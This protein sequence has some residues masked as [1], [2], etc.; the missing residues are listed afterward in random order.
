M[1]TAKGNVS[2]ELDS[3]RIPLDD[4]AKSEAAGRLIVHSAE[5]ASGPL[6]QELSALLTQQASL[7]RV[8]DDSVVRFQLTGGRVYHEGLEIEFPELSLRTSGWVGLDQSLA[9]T[10]E[11]SV[12]SK[13]FAGTPLGDTLKKQ[14]VRIPIGGTLHRPR[15]DHRE[16]AKMS[17]QMI[18]GVPRAI[19]T[20][21]SRQLDRLFPPP[22]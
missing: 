17:R 19:G 2:I 11:M 14:A 1:T 6:I 18:Q 12:P 15:L 16:I 10:A 5:V 7:A 3:C 13:W 4:P 22:K 8:K 9:V 20:E 21:V